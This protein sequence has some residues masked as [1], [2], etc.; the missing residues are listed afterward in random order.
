MREREEGDGHLDAGAG[1]GR[2]SAELLRG[3]LAAQVPELWKRCP[4]TE[5]IEEV[6]LAG[7]HRKDREGMG[8]G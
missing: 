7:S 2:W 1:G 8:V 3:T 4:V 5:G 6:G